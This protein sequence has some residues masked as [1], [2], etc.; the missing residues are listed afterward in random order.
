MVEFFI[1]VF[2]ETVN[3]T[4]S[5]DSCITGTI[6][7]TLKI[8]KIIVLCYLV[9]IQ[10]IIYERVTASQQSSN[11]FV[12]PLRVV[13]L[14]DKKKGSMSKKVSMSIKRLKKVR[15][16]LKFKLKLL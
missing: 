9:L 4:S 5:A 16:A 14:T 12:E 1:K 15:L 8:I 13:R 10:K 11:V 6:F 7:S 2:W 3:W